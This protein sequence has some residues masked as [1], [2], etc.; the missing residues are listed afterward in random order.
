MAKSA[1]LEAVLAAEQM[2]APP[3]VTSYEECYDGMVSKPGFREHAVPE[4]RQEGYDMFIDKG[5]RLLRDIE[6]QYRCGG[7]CYQEGSLFYVAKDIGEGKPQE[8]C[9]GKVFESAFSEIKLLCLVTGTVLLVNFCCS[10]GLCA[11]ITHIENEG[12]LEEPGS[13]FDQLRPNAPKKLAGKW[14]AVFTQIVP[15][16]EQLISIT[17]YEITFPNGGGSFA[18]GNYTASRDGSIIKKHG[19]EMIKFVRDGDELR[20]L[21]S[22]GEFAKYSRDGFGTTVVYQPFVDPSGRDDSY[23]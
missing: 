17:D 14:K 20:V 23:I 22:G 7:A 13:D 3:L 15:P 5:W 12:P 21:Y 8:E 4:E 9:L 10:L 6:G 16:D 19:Q 18:N 11:G 1:Q 2:S